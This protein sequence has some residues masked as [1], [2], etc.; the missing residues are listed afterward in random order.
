MTEMCRLYLT[1]IVDDRTLPSWLY[2][3]SFLDLLTVS[4][5]ILALLQITHGVRFGSE[6]IARKRAW[7]ALWN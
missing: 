2:S 3:L 5:I 1:L 4:V 6:S 7:R